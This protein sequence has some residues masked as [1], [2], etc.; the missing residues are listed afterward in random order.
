MR[1]LTCTGNYSSF[2]ERDIFT[3]ALTTFARI[4][5]LE[6]FL[7]KRNIKFTLSRYTIPIPHTKSSVY[8]LLPFPFATIIPDEYFKLICGILCK[9]NRIKSAVGCV[10]VPSTLI[11]LLSTNPKYNTIKG[12]QLKHSCCVSK[13]GELQAYYMVEVQ[14]S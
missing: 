9:F 5:Q 11:K 14:G 1:L 4:E 3:M 6:Y 8:L 12:A 2:I 10:D 13:L 7:K